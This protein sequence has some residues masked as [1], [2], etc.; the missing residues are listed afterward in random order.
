MVLL[1][2]KWVGATTVC[3]ADLQSL[4]TTVSLAGWLAG[5][6]QEQGRP[7][8]PCDK[9]AAFGVGVGRLAAF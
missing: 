9:W 3:G 7:Q 8:R 6:R 1:L 5:C 4:R 2:S